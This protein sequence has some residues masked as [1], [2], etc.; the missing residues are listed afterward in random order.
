M[1]GPSNA[2]LER[3][4]PETPPNPYLKRGR[5][6]A[7][8][9]AIQAMSTAPW[10]GGTVQRWIRAPDQV[11]VLL[12]TAIQ[13]HTR[14]ISEKEASRRLPRRLVEALARF[15]AVALPLPPV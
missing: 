5:L 4:F 14:A 15:A 9:E 8:I 7:I 13:L 6:A 1:D 3:P 12:N 10:G 2:D 11:G